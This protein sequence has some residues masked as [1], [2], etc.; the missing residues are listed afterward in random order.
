MKKTWGILRI[1]LALVLS[2]PIMS[3][4]ADNNGPRAEVTPLDVTLAN[5]SRGVIFGEAAI[6][7]D[8]TVASCFNCNKL[9]TVHLGTGEYQVAF[10]SLGNGSITAAN[11]FSRWVQVDTLSTG[12]LN[13]WCTTADRIGVPGAVYVQC[14]QEGGSG[15][16][17][18]SVPAD[19]SFFLFVAR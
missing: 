10:Q 8:G 4:A 2:A 1:V 19:V 18:N 6:N 3:R 14:Q 11:G 5:A 13:A 7:P 17:G 12:S 15:S 16:Q 9:N